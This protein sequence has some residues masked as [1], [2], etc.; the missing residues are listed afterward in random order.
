MNYPHDPNK[1]PGMGLSHSKDWAP[2]ISIGSTTLKKGV[3][4]IYAVLMNASDNGKIVYLNGTGMI[5]QMYKPHVVNKWVDIDLDD[6]MVQFNEDL[7]YQIEIKGK[8]FAT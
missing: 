5:I 4:H 3:Y 6:E 7:E 8:S 1:Y 2:L